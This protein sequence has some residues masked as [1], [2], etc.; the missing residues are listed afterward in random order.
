MQKST[1]QTS[2]SQ[3]DLITNKQATLSPFAHKQESAN[4]ADYENAF[5]RPTIIRQ[6]IAM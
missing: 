6:R 1:I 2:P 5:F 3:M 4:Y